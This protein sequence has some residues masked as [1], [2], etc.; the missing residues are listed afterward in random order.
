RCQILESNLS[1]VSLLGGAPTSLVIEPKRIQRTAKNHIES[2]ENSNHNMGDQAQP[3]NFAALKTQHTERNIVATAIVYII[4]KY[5]Q[6]FPCRVLL[7]SGSQINMIS[8]RM[9]HMTGLKRQYAPIQFQ[10]AHKTNLHRFV[11]FVLAKYI[12]AMAY[13]LFEMIARSL[14][15]GME[16]TVKHLSAKRIP[17]KCVGLKPIVK[18]CKELAIHPSFEFEKRRNAPIKYNRE[19]RSKG[20]YAIKTVNQIKEPRGVHFVMDR[21]RNGRHVEIRMN[22]KDVQR[23][24]SLIRSPAAG[25]KERRARCLT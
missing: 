5:N 17:A 1:S 25:L 2:A 21:L 11:N 6:R 3:K 14:S 8:E 12:L 23:N 20:S 13:S 4:S 24:I 18:E 10:C 22:V 15:F 19:M 16:N 9:V 7:Y